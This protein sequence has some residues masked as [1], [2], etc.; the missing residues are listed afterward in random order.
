MRGNRVVTAKRLLL[1]AVLGAGLAQAPGTGTAARADSWWPFGSVAQQDYD[2]AATALRADPGN[3]ALLAAFANI[4]SRIGNYE[5]AIGALEAILLQNPGLNRVRV[6]LGVMYFRV[7]AYDVSRFHLERALASGTLP[8]DAEAR[9]RSFLSANEGRLDG[10]NVSGYLSAGL[11]YDT[12]PLMVSDKDTLS[13]AIAPWGDTELPGNASVEDDFAGFLQGSFL[14]REELGNQWGETWDTTGFT[15][16]RWQFELDEVD[17]GYL[18]LTTGPRL[19]VLPGQVDNAFVRPYLQADVT[20]VQHDFSNTTGGGGVTLS[21]RFGT[22][23]TATLDG[24]ARW[25]EAD[26]GASDAFIGSGTGK[27]S[28][29]LNEDILLSFGGAYERTEAEADYRSR[30]RI[31]G[32]VDLNVRYDAPW[33]LTDYPWEFALHGEIS[34]VFYDEP[35][36]SVSLDK[37]RDDTNSRL[38]VRNTVGLSASWFIFAE[39]GLYRNRSPINNYE[40][41]NEYIAVGATWRF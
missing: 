19:A 17:V 26:Q 14:W 23:L 25:R 38:V 13:L 37:K 16:W 30:E 15:Y 35:H 40:V 1:A 12:N 24:N 10:T 5:A 41:E 33:N 28:M 27:L 3:P 6:E 29:A 21:K 22:W 9:A 34:S 8:A 4:A 11:R 7:A 31:T 39:G 18:R 2:T 32:F 20:L 36:P